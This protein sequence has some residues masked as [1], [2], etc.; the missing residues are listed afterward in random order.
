MYVCS[1]SN[2]FL[3]QINTPLVKVIDISASAAIKDKL[4]KADVKFVLLEGKPVQVEFLVKDF[5]YYEFTTGYIG[6]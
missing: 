4:Q 3:F 2:S 5:Q 1:F 6:D